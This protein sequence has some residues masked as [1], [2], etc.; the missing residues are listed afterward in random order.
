MNHKLRKLQEKFES[1]KSLPYPFVNPVILTEDDGF[2]DGNYRK[3]FC[4]QPGSN[5]TL[6]SMKIPFTQFTLQTQEGVEYLSNL[7]K[8][9]KETL[10]KFFLDNNTPFQS[11]IVQSANEDKVAKFVEFENRFDDYEEFW[12]IWL[13]AY[14]KSHNTFKYQKEIKR[15]FSLNYPKKEILM[16]NTEREFLNSLDEE[17][18]IYRG[19]TKEEAKS[20]DYG[21][22]WTLDKSIAEFFANSFLHNYDTYHLEKTLVELKVKKTDIIAYFNS[23]ESEIIYIHKRG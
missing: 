8:Q 10:E 12:A 3:E 11:Q 4:F 18:T 21:V 23:K 14:Q 6:L 15:I 17:V 9:Q 16:D 22:S 19:M 20:E 7:K 5:F 2:V 1:R 13:L